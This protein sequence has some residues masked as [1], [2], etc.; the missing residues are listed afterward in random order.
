VQTGQDGKAQVSFYLSDAVT[1]FRVL[2]EAIGAG[3]AGRD[4][5]VIKSSLPFSM[6]VKLP[7]EVS[8]GGALLALEAQAETGGRSG[9]I[10]FLKNPETGRRFQARVEGKGKVVIRK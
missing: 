8:E 9:D 3:S 4:E 2:S 6:A 1:S 7:V 5:T 10:V